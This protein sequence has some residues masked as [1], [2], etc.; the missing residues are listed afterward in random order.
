MGAAPSID[1]LEARK[2]LIQAR[3]DLHRAEM[4]WH[5]RQ[6]TAPVQ[7]FKAGFTRVMSNPIARWTIMGSL[8]FFLVTGRL[9][10]VRKAAVWVAPFLLQR[11]RGLL[12]GPLTKM[13]FQ[14]FAASLLRR[15]SH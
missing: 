9:R 15:L 8:G 7:S 3:M 12:L 14:L 4:A 11:V 10:F 13:G 1:E 5:Y 6:I 2:R